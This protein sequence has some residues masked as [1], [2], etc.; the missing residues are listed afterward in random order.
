MAISMDNLKSLFQG[1]GKRATSSRRNLFAILTLGRT[2][3]TALAADLDSHPNITCH[4]EML[5]KE[6]REAWGD[7]APIA[8]A[9]LSD[10]SR[11]FDGYLDFLLENCKSNA[12]TV[13]MKILLNHLRESEAIAPLETM[14]CRDARFIYLLR[15]P[16]AVSVSLGLAG[17]RSLFNI[18][19]DD[20]QY[21][22][23]MARQK[24]VVLDID[25][26][27]HHA[28]SMN[29]S[30]R[31]G[32]KKLRKLRRPHLTVY[33]EN[34]ISDRVG[35]LRS[36]YKF[37]DVPFHQPPIESSFQKVTSENIWDDVQNADAVRRA[38][39][40]EGFHI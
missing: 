40:A 20:P 1:K 26:V 31:K 16:A 29:K 4:Q 25:W 39:I 5:R 19:R 33:Y 27:C 24:R 2:G 18:H 34:Y 7:Q 9:F 6:P 30:I 3:S 38:L 10:P 35:M 17:A 28:N 12:R 13:G 23:V 21:A 15:N 14:A 37:L 32:K 8:H 11:S 22:E 36:I